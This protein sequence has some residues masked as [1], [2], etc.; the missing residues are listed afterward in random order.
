MHRI[1][2]TNSMTVHPRVCGE[3][4]LQRPA[5]FGLGGSSP[6][7]RGTRSLRRAAV[8]TD[9]FIP[10]C[11]GNAPNAR[12]MR[13]SSTVHP[14]V[15]GERGCSNDRGI[16]IRGSSP[17]VR[18]THFLQATFLTGQSQSGKAHQL[19][20]LKSQTQ[21]RRACTRRSVSFSPV[22]LLSAPCSDGGLSDP[23]G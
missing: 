1:L 3:R 13:R 6:R 19:F 22:A 14:R 20:S 5:L 15:C 7:V 16:P 10:A 8:P 21:K 11:A 12:T 18:G 4:W 2:T 17:R 23:Q 9:R